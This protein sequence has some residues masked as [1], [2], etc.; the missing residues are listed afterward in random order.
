MT[1]R[2]EHEKLR[3]LVRCLAGV[4]QVALRGVAEREVDVLAGAVDSREGLLVQ[5]A[6]EAEAVGDAPERDHHELL[7]V[8]G[9]V[10]GLEH[11]RELELPGRHLVVARLGRDAE[12][13]EL[14]LDGDH[15]P[16][17]ALGDRAEVVVLELL[18]LRG[19]RAE[20]RAS[21]EHEVGPRVVEALVDEEVLLLGAAVR[22]DHGRVDVAEELQDAL[23]VLVQHLIRAKERRLG[24]ERLA[25]PR[26]EARGNA[27]RRAGLRVEEVRGAGHV[28][29]GVTARLERRADAAV[30]EARR[31]GLALDERLARELRDRAAVTVGAVEAVVLLRRQAREGIEDVG[32][33]RGAHGERPVLHRRGH[34]VRDLRIEQGSGFDGALERLEH[35][36]GEVGLHRR[37][38]EYV[39]R[40]GDVRGLSFGV[41]V[42]RDR[43]VA[44]RRN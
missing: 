22:D 13:E 43:G 34:G 35:L 28:P 16:H 41:A 2:A 26:D 17:D 44:V 4:E 23:G 6:R 14:L 18:P 10:A 37:K 19:H 5:E 32:V 27:E 29:R 42:R 31:V 40:V 36:L 7:V 8:G 33:V 1:A 12:L 9:E 24:V 30:G 20:E 3:V 21:R 11:G 15:E 25:G 39:R 38:P